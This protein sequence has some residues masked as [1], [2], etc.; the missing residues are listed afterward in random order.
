[1]TPPPVV[2]EDVVEEPTAACGPVVV[3]ELEVEL[4]DEPHPA[5]ATAT[6]SARRAGT[7]CI[8]PPLC[9]ELIDGHARPGQV[10]DGYAQV[11]ARSKRICPIPSG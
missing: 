5:I 9:R 8:E 2:D 3:V 11:I 6:P 10:T 4:L 7:V 1:L